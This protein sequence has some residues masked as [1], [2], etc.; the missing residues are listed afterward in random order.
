M[1]HF[2]SVQ[3]KLKD[4]VAVKQAVQD[5]GLT[6]VESEEE[7]NVRGYQGNLEKSKLVIRA[8]KHYDIG[9]HLTQDGYEMVADWW[10]IE[11]ET[12]LKEEV[13]VERFKQRYAYNKVI[14]EIKS[15]GFTLEEEED[16]AGEIRLTVR[17]W[18]A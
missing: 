15:R 14:K 7:V 9:L 3:T 8:S 12:G 2:T 16:K 4:L 1:S 18:E 11:M 13:W 6:F 10:G 5:L 17:K